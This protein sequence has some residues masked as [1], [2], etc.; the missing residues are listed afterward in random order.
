MARRMYTFSRMLLLLCLDL[1]LAP[2]FYRRKLNRIRHAFP[3]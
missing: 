2:T 3:S 1:T